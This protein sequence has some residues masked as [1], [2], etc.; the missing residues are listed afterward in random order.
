MS[1]KDAK[2]GDQERLLDAALEFIKAAPDEEFNRLLQ[3]SEDDPI[4]LQAKALGAIDA[5]LGRL[6]KK[7]PQAASSASAS[8][9]PISALTVAQ[10]R[11]AAVSLGVRRQVLAAFRE[12]RVIADSVP[13]RFLIR[14][15]AIARTTVEDL[16]DALRAPGA[17][18]TSRSFKAETAPHADGQI[19]FDQ[20][21]KDA[22]H[23]EAERTEL[24]SEDD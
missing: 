12:H 14:L 21:L 2:R 10:L 11:E 15:A 13:R 3:D 7:S 9:D 16:T 8:P 24:M 23:S 6:E 5:A 18:S 1:H 17:L 22:G 20:L 4:E 19:T